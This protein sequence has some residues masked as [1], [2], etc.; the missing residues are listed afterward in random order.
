MSKR[1]TDTPGK[2]RRAVDAG[3]VGPVAVA[4]P[5]AR[6]FQQP[7]LNSFQVN[8]AAVVADSSFCAVRF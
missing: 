8:L 7:R 1:I 2:L 3:S 4:R 6:E 5:A